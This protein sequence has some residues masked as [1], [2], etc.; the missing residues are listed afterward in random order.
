MI[1]LEGFILAGGASSRM[2]RDKSTLDFGGRTA[3]E[4][5]AEALSSISS[6][7]SIVGSRTGAHPICVPNIPDL[8][9][10]WGALGGI[11][12]ALRSCSSKWA[13]IVACDL[14]LVNAP[15]FQRLVSI[16]ELEASDGVDAVVP[17]QTDGRP[18]P[19][20]ALYRCEPCLSQTEL[21]IESGEHTP[22][23]LL[24]AV[25]TRWVQPGE[26]SDLPEAD[27][28]FFNSNTPEEYRQARLILAS[29]V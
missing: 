1:Q 17:I 7:I 6:Q 24:A 20:C 25:S 19:L 23:A 4:V 2:G 9:P 29:K 18:Q 11:H 12:A 15:L 8:K 5:I 27:H 28:L 10:D 14:P 26:I 3:V 16:A 21:L 13:A 22:R